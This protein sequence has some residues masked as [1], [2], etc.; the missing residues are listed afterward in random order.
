SLINTAKL[1]D[2]DPRHYLTDVLER[3]VSGRTK[4][5]QLNTLLPWNWKTERDGSEAKLAA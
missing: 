1:H 2:M 3:I 5:N 4:I